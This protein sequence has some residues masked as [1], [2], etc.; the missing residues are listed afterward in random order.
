MVNIL[1]LRRSV[2]LADKIGAERG[3]L[4]SVLARI[5]NEWRV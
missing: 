1:K 3:A 2:V 5:R 4:K